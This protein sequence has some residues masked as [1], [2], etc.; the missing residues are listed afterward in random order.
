VV[1]HISKNRDLKM[2]H[3]HDASFSSSQLLLAL[4]PLFVL[5]VT[6]LAMAIGLGILLPGRTPDNAERSEPIGHSSEAITT[7]HK[8]RKAV[9]FAEMCSIFGYGY[10]EHVVTTP[11]GYLLA[12]HRILPGD[13]DKNKDSDSA[14]LNSKPVVFFQHG[15]LTNSEFFTA[16]SDVHRSLPFVLIDNGY[17]V[18]LGNNRYG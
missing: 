18:W 12:L 5:V 1:N 6:L 11:D 10:E 17:D 3:I 2:S 9:D 8:L 15:L 4:T 13:F 16:L 7:A 14:P